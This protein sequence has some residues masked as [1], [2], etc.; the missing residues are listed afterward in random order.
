MKTMKNITRHQIQDA[1]HVALIACVLLLNCLKNRSTSARVAFLFELRPS[2][3]ESRGY[4]SLP[5][6]TVSADLLIYSLLLATDI[7]ENSVIYMVRRTETSFTV[8]IH[9]RNIQLFVSSHRIIYSINIRYF[10]Q[11][12]W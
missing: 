10:K 1:R 7:N 9:H 2:G 12:T 5:S 3:L 4:E 11:P 6:A 8:P